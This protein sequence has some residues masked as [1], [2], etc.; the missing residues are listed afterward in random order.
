MDGGLVVREQRL[1]LAQQAKRRAPCAGLCLQLGQ[2]LAQRALLVIAAPGVQQ[3]RPADRQPAS[4]RSRRWQAAIPP[5]GRR[6]ARAPIDPSTAPAGRSDQR[7]RCCRPSPLTAWRVPGRACCRP[8]VRRATPRRVA[9]ATGDQGLGR[10]R[11]DAIAHFRRIVEQQRQCHGEH[12]GS[13]RRAFPQLRQTHRTPQRD[14]VGPWE[15]RIDQGFRLLGPMCEQ[16]GDRRQRCIVGRAGLAWIVGRCQT[17]HGLSLGAETERDHRAR[18]RLA[19][20]AAGERRCHRA[21]GHLAPQLLP[22]RSQGWL[23]KSN[24]LVRPAA[25]ASC[26]AMPDRGDRLGAPAMMKPCG[27]GRMATVSALA[28]T[29]TPSQVGSKASSGERSSAGTPWPSRRCVPTSSVAPVFGSVTF[30][31]VLGAAASRTRRSSATVALIGRSAGSR[32]PAVMRQA[33]AVR[34]RDNAVAGSSCTRITV[35]AGSI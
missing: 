32:G 6:P 13:L 25:R 1:A 16:G 18:H 7:L 24:R 21:L 8:C 9:F 19:A 23:G 3:A 4:H 33:S 20:R 12:G 31:T 28:S 27:V 29:A 11:Q 30:T 35:A 26:S 10:E 5:H 22:Q 34:D 15:C 2:T 17:Q 14:V